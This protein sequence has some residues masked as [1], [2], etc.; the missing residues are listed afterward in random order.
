MKALLTPVYFQNRIIRTGRLVIIVHGLMIWSVEDIYEIM[1]IL[2]WMS[3]LSRVRRSAMIFMSDE[4]TSENHLTSDKKIGIHSKQYII[5]FLMCYFMPWSITQTPLN[6]HR[7]LISPSSPRKLILTWHC[8][9]TTIQ[10][11]MSRERALIALWRHIRQ[12]F[13]HAMIRTKALMKNSRE[14]RFSTTRYSRLS[15]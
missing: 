8:D 14:Y 6:N 13:L 4:V 2:P 12:L 5:S 10:S 3:F 15:V 11:L 1:Y 9:V 7:L